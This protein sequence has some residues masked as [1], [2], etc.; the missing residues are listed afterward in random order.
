MILF[1]FLF[2]L[3][4]AAPVAPPNVNTLFKISARTHPSWT[5]SSL[6]LEKYKEIGALSSTPDQYLPK[7]QALAAND[8]CI[9]KSCFRYKLES[10]LLAESTHPASE[11]RLNRDE[12]YVTIVSPLTNFH[13]S[14]HK[15]ANEIESG[16]HDNLKLYMAKVLPEIEFSDFLNLDYDFQCRG[17]HYELTQVVLQQTVVKASIKLQVSVPPECSFSNF[18][19]RLGDEYTAM[20]ETEVPVNASFVCVKGRSR[21][22][23]MRN[24]VSSLPKLTYPLP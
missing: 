20:M 24:A 18:D 12:Y 16:L 4:A 23:S 5:V 7:A 15:P 6:L 9:E 10:A 22:C 21:D 1:I 19:P 11:C 8:A 2:A 17:G 13:N 14:L 3:V